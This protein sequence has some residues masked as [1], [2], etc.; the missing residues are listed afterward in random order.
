M[1]G[2]DWQAREGVVPIILNTKKS[3]TSG[4]VALVFIS[5][6]LFMLRE[7]EGW[8]ISWVWVMFPLWS[9]PV[10]AI[11]SAV[12]ITLLIALAHVGVFIISILQKLSNS[13]TRKPEKN[14]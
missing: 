6:V 12:F 1:Y 13:E 9:I 8:N 14:N 4:P 3:S 7:H 10:T 11:V 2:L 5:L